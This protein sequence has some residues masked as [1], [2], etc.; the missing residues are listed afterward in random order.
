MPIG[1]PWTNYCP[2]WKNTKF[3]VLI[4]YHRVIKSGVTE[5]IMFGLVVKE[6]MNLRIHRIVHKMWHILGVIN[7]LKRYVFVSAMGS[8]YYSL[9]MSN[10][11]FIITNRDVNVIAYQDYRNWPSKLWHVAGILH[12]LKLFL[13]NCICRVWRMYLTCVWKF[14]MNFVQ[15][16]LA[17]YFHDICLNMIKRVKTTFLEKGVQGYLAKIKHYL[18]REDKDSKN[19]ESI[20]DKILWY[21]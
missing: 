12:I 21:M 19:K 14:D 11:Q 8:K 4:Y 16:K 18:R 5:F 1:L 20:Y 15:N 3:M 13:T 7:M 2:M 10:F 17:N 6:S 9:I